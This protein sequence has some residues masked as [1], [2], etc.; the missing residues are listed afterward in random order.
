MLILLSSS[1]YLYEVFILFLLNKKTQLIFLVAITGSSACLAGQSDPFSRPK[2]PVKETATPSV[3]PAYDPM[4]NMMGRGVEYH[5]MFNQE[6]PVE[7][8]GKFE[9]EN[10]VFKGKIN[11]VT[12]Y[13]DTT[14]SKYVFD[15]GE[16]S[17]V[18][19]VNIEPPKL[20]AVNY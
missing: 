20:E 14:A 8:K 11:G 12:M 3:M 19:N 17:V 2:P 5:N 1:V 16:I 18:Q 6:T 10:F 15:K 4:M 13:F 9:G 7:A